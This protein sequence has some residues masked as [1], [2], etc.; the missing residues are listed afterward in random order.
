[1]INSGDKMGNASGW[2][3][4]AAVEMKKGRFKKYLEGRFPRH[5]DGAI[6]ERERGFKRQLQEFRYFTVSFPPTCLNLEHLHALNLFS[7]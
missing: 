2:R 1:M 7:Q 3:R 5:G 6:M 4:A